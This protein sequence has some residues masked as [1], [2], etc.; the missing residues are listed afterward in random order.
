MTNVTGLPLTTGVTGNLP[1]TNLNSGTSASASTFWRGDGS[2]ATPASGGT[3]GGST[4]QVQYNN[5]GVFGGIT[6]ATTN[7]TALTLVAPVLGTPASATLTNATGLPLTTGVTGN[8]PVT[9]LNSGTSASATTFW[10]G[11]ATWATPAGGGSSV[12]ATLY[13]NSTQGGF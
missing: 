13:I 4:T 12:G 7:G 5:A 11:D 8:L 9:N 1:V 10:R 3:P 2:W 6:G